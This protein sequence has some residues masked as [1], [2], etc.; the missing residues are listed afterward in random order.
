MGAEFSERHCRATRES[1]ADRLIA[2]ACQD[3]RTSSAD[4]FDGKTL[5][6]DDHDELISSG[7]YR[8]SSD[9]PGIHTRLFLVTATDPSGWS[10]IYPNPRVWMECEFDSLV[11]SLGC[12]ALFGF[13]SQKTFAWAWAKYRHGKQVDSCLYVEPTVWSRN[14]E[15]G[16]GDEPPPELGLAS[17]F[18]SHGRAFTYRT[19]WWVLGDY[20]ALAAEH[21]S[22]FQLVFR[23][24]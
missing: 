11:S 1:V 23:H 2:T 9:E 7:E 16:P 22:P 15:A 6:F 18:A 21:R 17:A 4:V 8:I 3:T 10:V 13:S 19:F 5:A 12:D 24:T 14:G 20:C